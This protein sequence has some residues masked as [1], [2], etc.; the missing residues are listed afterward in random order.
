MAFAPRYEFVVKKIKDMI[1]RVNFQRGKK[2]L[3]KL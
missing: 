1:Q 2:C 3:R